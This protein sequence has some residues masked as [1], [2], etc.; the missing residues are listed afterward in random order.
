MSY[1]LLGQ[2]FVPPDL[3]GKVTGE[4]KYAEDFRAEGM[5]FCRL[6]LSPM[7][8]ARVR[9]IDASRALAMD[10]VLGIITADDVTPQAEPNE[11]ILTNNP[12]YVGAPILAVAA[13]T[14]QLA[15]DAIDAIRLDMEPLPFTV[16][17]LESLFP[18]G[19]DARTDGNCVDNRRI[20]GR[21]IVERV[22]WTARDFA[23]AGEG[24]MP[25]GQPH[26]EWSYGD[27]DAEFERSALVLDESFV[28][29]NLSHHSLE[30]RS[31][32]AY[33]ENGRCF[34]YA[35]IQS[36][37]FTVPQLAGLIGISADDLVLIGE[38]CGGGFGSKA[39]GYPCMSIS[40]H[41]ARHVGR[42]VMLRISRSE[43]YFLGA[44]RCGFQGRIR[45]GFLAD[46]RV[47]AVDMYVVQENGPSIGFPD[48]PASGDTVSL[49]YQPAAMRWRGMSVATNTP[50]RSAQRGPGYNQTS[51][52]I[53][54]IMDK[55]A[56]ELDI[57]RLEI[58]RINAPTVET[59]YGENRAGQLTSCFM[60]E[61]LEIG[62]RE[63]NWDER[64]AV[65]GQRNGSKVRGV[66]I[67]QAY[68]PA[69][70]FGFDGLVR[71]T[72]DGMLHIH[73]GVGNLGTFSHSGTS[74]I[75]A[76]VLK[77]DWDNVVIERGD[78][79]RHLP[80]NV[81]QFGSNTSFTMAR[82][83]YVAAMDALG[84][85]KEIAAMELGGTPDDYEVGDHRVFRSTEPST[86]IS[87]ADAAR[88]AIELG[89]RFDGHELPD[90]INV[91]TRNSATA[92]A[93]SGLIG[94]ARDNLPINGAPSAFTVGFIE[95]ELDVETGSIDILDYVGVADCGTVIHPQSLHSQI[96]SGAVMGFG[97]A[98]TERFI[99]DHQNGLPANIGLYQAK[100]PS[101]LDVPERARAFA[102]NEPDPQSPMGTKGVG[103][104]VMGSG[105]AAMLC[106]ISDALGG[107]YFNRTP[108]TADM[109]VNA[110]AG[111]AQSFGPLDVNTA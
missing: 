1:L 3:H 42:P 9:S 26:G 76:E 80:W 13:E 40:A 39:A 82:T 63:F 21:P 27:L 2:D 18:G 8:H 60:H 29:A 81:G 92:L 69:G 111:R 7:P 5:V 67:G 73:T 52:A 77:A 78:S 49:L 48:W 91:M 43:E 19:P 20:P 79:R 23:D 57:D 30:P 31:S 109:I 46:G 47:N 108:I 32:M 36:Q 11:P 61:A 71:I 65:S 97:M 59:R 99:Y 93:G 107:H 37:S 58:R 75:A 35:S 50:P 88:L 110:A 53:E 33:W 74:R 25:M 62:A 10:G 4:A 86:G 87:F 70:M 105:T 94:V 24:Q 104:P 41:M 98:H 28:T 54:P 89:G 51:A 38:T 84:K 103:E 68:H 12:R 17:P 100:P 22:K 95:I 64:R 72:P 55:A 44:A 34:V 101:F 90:D 56:R 102:V 6:M 45:M 16:D 14:E 85:L 15:Q 106:A 66:G 83:N 96:L